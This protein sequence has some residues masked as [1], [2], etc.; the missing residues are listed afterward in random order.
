[1]SMSKRF[2]VAWSLIRDYFGSAFVLLCQ[3]LLWEYFKPRLEPVLFIN[4]GAFLIAAMIDKLR[5]YGYDDN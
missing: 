5:G 2:T 1:M 3:L 4:F